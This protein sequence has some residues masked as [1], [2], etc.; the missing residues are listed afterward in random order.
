LESARHARQLAFAAGT[1]ELAVGDPAGLPWS[2]DALITPMKDK[3]MSSK[4]RWTPGARP[5]FHLR[6][7]RA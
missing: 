1:Q 4:R 3:R 7:R 6:R 5:R 2:V